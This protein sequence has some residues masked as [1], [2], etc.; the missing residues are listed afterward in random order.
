MSIDATR[1]VWAR[2]EAGPRLSSRAKLVLLALADF[3]NA[4]TRQCNPSV[5]TLRKR[6]GLPA[7][8][9]N[10]TLLE[11]VNA[12]DLRIER[13]GGRTSNRYQLSAPRPHL[14]GQSESSTPDTSPDSRRPALRTDPR[15]SPDSRRRT[16]NH[17]KNQRATTWQ[18]DPSCIACGGDGFNSGPNNTH[19]PCLCRTYT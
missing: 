9:V 1:A 11:L 12:G 17:E 19:A 2:I 16:M 14:S 5:S 10:L 4:E 3:E 18:A 7:S 6:T 15:S 8:T 13:G